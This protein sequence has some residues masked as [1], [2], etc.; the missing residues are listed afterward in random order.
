MIW[1]LLELSMLAVKVCKTPRF[2]A[3]MGIR[4]KYD[5]NFIFTF[6][7]VKVRYDGITT[8]K[9]FNYGNLLK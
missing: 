2:V 1:H 5:S 9:I 6:A 3:A 7:I 8:A 4:K